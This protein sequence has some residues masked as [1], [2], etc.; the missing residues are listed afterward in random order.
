MRSLKGLTKEKMLR[1]NFYRT[2]DN[3]QAELCISARFLHFLLKAHVRSYPEKAQALSA[4]S[5]QIGG[6][7]HHDLRDVQRSLSE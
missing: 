2:F 1:Y 4:A 3:L 6:R 5:Q 7:L